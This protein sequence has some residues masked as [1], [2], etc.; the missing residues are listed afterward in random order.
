MRH[1]ARRNHTKTFAVI[2]LIVL[3]AM[4]AA[5]W[6]MGGGGGGKAPGPQT[7][8]IVS[9][10]VIR[11]NVPLELREVG[12]VTAYETVS[13]K[14]RLDSQIVEVLFRDGD[15]VKA[16]APLFIL[17]GR[18]MQAQL[19]QME[20]TL[21]RDEAQLQNLK[22][23]YER[24]Q[25][26]IQTG[27]T[28]QARLDETRA[29]YESQRATIGATKAATENLRV[30]LGYMRITAP[31]DGRTGTIN[32][33]AG[34]TVKAN[35]ERPL[36]TINK[37]RPIRVQ[38]A[39]SQVY[40]DAVRDAMRLETL[41]VTAQREGGDAVTGGTLEYIDNAVDPATGTF[42]ARA[43]FANEDEALWPGMFVTLTLMLGEEKGA[44]TIPE[45]AVQHAQ[46]GDF[47]FVIRDAKALR[48]D[49]KIAR[50]HSGNA[51][52]LSGLEEGERVAVDGLLSLRDGSAVSEH[53]RAPSSGPAKEP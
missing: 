45:V 48:R 7:V 52:L 15:N 10:P 40:F 8:P 34:N 50:T 37:I 38:T 53:A 3:A 20:A 4:L 49:V 2:G 47:V 19:N 12:T 39:L 41:H 9:A 51:V 26:L 17:D 42:K 32:V 5:W 23:Q 35:D 6:R 29:A 44:L 22:Q 21:R 27:F 30:Q 43:R 31:I 24:A 11:Q 18:S 1:G 36:V 46:T 16:G 33:T 25:K 28:S 14:A 13:V